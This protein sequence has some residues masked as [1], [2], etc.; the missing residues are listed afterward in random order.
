MRSRR[1]LTAGCAVDAV[2]IHWRAT[3]ADGTPVVRYEID[4]TGQAKVASGCALEPVVR[5]ATCVDA[6]KR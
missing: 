5:A 3:A 4:I 2:F 1:G 6:R